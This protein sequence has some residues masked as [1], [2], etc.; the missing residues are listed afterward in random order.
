MTLKSLSYDAKSLTYDIYK[1]HF[2]MTLTK[3]LSYGTYLNYFLMKRS[4]ITF[5]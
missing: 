3:S 1:N 2:I 5:L 4:K